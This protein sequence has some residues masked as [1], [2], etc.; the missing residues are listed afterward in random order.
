[1]EG[2]GSEA[3]V[4]VVGAGRERA[5]K[6]EVRRERVEEE[7]AVAAGSAAEE[8]VEAAAEVAVVAAWVVKVTAVAVGAGW[9]V[10]VGMGWEEAG[11]ALRGGSSE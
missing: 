4:G 11:K 10:E 6:V 9:A 5:G 2:A 7:E 3:V 8:A 1:M